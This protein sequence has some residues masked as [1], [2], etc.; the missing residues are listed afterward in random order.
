MAR[1]ENNNLVIIIV[2]VK[3]AHKTRIDEMRVVVGVTE[4][5]TKLAIS[6]WAGRTYAQKLEGK[7]G[8]GRPK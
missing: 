5:G 1:F 4:I 3:R 8:R 7:W 2:G 6:T